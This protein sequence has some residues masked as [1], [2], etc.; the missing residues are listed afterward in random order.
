MNHFP[1]F[2]RR[3]WPGQLRLMIQRDKYR[4]SPPRSQ[5][6]P[7]R[8]WWGG[9][10]HYP[11]RQSQIQSWRP[12][13]GGRKDIPVT[14]VKRKHWGHPFELPKGAQHLVWERERREEHERYLRRK[15]GCNSIYK[16]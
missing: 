1:W 16:T 8:V 9:G 15:N 6:T 12:Y 2:D 11:M 14:Q 10:S 3:M 5:T 13:Y 7:I 4:S